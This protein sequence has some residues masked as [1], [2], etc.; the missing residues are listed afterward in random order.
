[1]WVVANKEVILY[2]KNNDSRSFYD[3][4]ILFLPNIAAAYRLWKMPTG[5]LDPGEDIP[6]AATRELQEE[7]GLDATMEGIV[8]FRQAHSPSRSSDLFFVC[9]MILKD[10]NAK[11]QKQ[12]AE[13]ADICWMSVED[14]CNQERWQGSP[15][16]EALN[17][18]IRK[19][20][21]LAVQQ[22]AAGTNTHTPNGMI[23]HQSLPLGFA[24][25]TNAL[26]RSQL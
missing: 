12:E 21:L 9:H 13:I 1:V 10:P 4:I 7:T 6:E 18:S 19:A 5:L 3:S 15:V 14:Y 24:D 23:L 20:S 26:F 16:Y 17:D 25:G 22:K 11:W 8:C 2:P